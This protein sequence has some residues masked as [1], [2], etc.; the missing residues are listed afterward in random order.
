MK[1]I[2]FIDISGASLEFEFIP[3]QQKDLRIKE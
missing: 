1:N 2:S 3:K